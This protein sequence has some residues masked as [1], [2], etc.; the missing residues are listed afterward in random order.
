LPAQSAKTEQGPQ[1]TLAVCAKLSSSI[2]CS[3]YCSSCSSFTSSSSSFSYLFIYLFYFI[4]L[5]HVHIK[6]I[7]VE[8]NHQGQNCLYQVTMVHVT[9]YTGYAG[10]NTLR[11]SIK[12]LVL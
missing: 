4:Y 8:Q 7:N 5:F 2:S 11:L 10:E 3:C 6:Q 1:R 9:Q 12:T